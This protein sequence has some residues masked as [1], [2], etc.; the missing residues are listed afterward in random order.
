MQPQIKDHTLQEIEVAV[1]QI[2]K[3]GPRREDHKAAELILN[4]F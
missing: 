1:K 4:R 3:L 2:K